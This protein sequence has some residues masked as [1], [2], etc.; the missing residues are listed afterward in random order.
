MAK[1]NDN[2]S[3]LDKYSTD[4]RDLPF[5]DVTQSHQ[6]RQQRNTD[7]D[8]HDRENDGHNLAGAGTSKTGLYDDL[9]FDASRIPDAPP[10]PP[11]VPAPVPAPRM[12]PTAPV[13]TAPPPPIAQRPQRLPSI[14]LPALRPSPRVE[15]LPT[16]VPLHTDGASLFE[17]LRKVP[18]AVYL[19]LLFGVLFLISSLS[20]G[21][22]TAQSS[23]SS[24]RAPVGTPIDALV[25]GECFL[26]PPGPG[27][28]TVVPTP[29]GQQH[30]GEVFAI[31]TGS[32]ADAL[33][34]CDSIRQGLSEELRARL[35]GDAV[36]TLLLGDS[37]HRCVV[38]SADRALVGSL[39]P[40]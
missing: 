12:P 36:F 39:T 23:S 38:L 26:D 19:P 15:R 24:E 18:R 7:R 20:D 33:E 30:G 31:V 9:V 34:Q 14:E 35:P 4:P 37:T 22:S 28:I 27:V 6:D 29:C 5:L 11:T 8:A 32:V 21:G 13:A 1:K 10:P 16:P 2:Y 17:R 40:S 25:P 3:W